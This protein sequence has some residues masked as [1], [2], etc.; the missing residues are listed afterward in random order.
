MNYK[1]IFDR[2]QLIKK[3]ISG[4]LT[5]EESL[6]LKEWVE[7]SEAN[8][9]LFEKLSNPEF[10]LSFDL[11]DSDAKAEN[12]YHNFIAKAMKLKRKKLRIR[13]L[14]IAAAVLCPLIIGSFLYLSVPQNIS[15]NTVVNST[16]I[17]VIKSG[18]SKAI[19]TLADGQTVNLN[20]NNKEICVKED[21]IIIDSSLT[22]KNNDTT[23]NQTVK[24]NTLRIPK[25]GEFQMTLSDGT[26]VWLNAD[27]EIIFPSSFDTDCR[28]VAIK[29]EVY[30]EVAK[31]KNH[32]FIVETKECSIEVL[33]TSF[34]VK[35]Y[36]NEESA[37]TTLVSGSV[38]MTRDQWSV[39]LAPNEQC[40]VSDN[41]MGV[42]KVEVDEYISWI[43][44]KLTFRDKSLSYIM[45]NIA[46]WYNV[47]IE[48]GSEELKEIE[49]N[50]AFARDETLNN[51]VY[52]LEMSSDIR[53]EI[54]EN[55][56]II[57]KNQ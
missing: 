7:S 40:I 29:G 44:N 37:T 3:S 24:H 14:S 19:L 32:P 57:N 39:V 41:S 20:E 50:G 9:K 1:T 45:A 35:C 36:D 18:H 25:G 34:N 55:K 48:F 38:K 52:M 16:T 49:L 54:K 23:F 42:S 13:R 12:S 8:K 11:A 15:S 43:N 5:N 10:I 33:G 6:A 56:L 26:K 4:E 28:R 17:P 51:I 22:I 21:N 27:S 30:F 53:F 31:K 47:E 46:R 2:S